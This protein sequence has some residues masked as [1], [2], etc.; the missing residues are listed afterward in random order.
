MESRSSEEFFTSGT[1]VCEALIWQKLR[2]RFS[3][4]NPEWNLEKEGKVYPKSW[5]RICG[6]NKIKTMKFSPG[7]RRDVSFSNALRFSNLKK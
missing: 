2:V 5:S 1:N 7:F 4:A 6:R 3:T